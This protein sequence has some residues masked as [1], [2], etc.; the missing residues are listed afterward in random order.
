MDLWIF[1]KERVISMPKAKYFVKN[2]MMASFFRA[3]VDKF[4]GLEEEAPVKKTY[5]SFTDL[6]D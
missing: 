4:C 1:K 6:S 3:F 5:A 2:D